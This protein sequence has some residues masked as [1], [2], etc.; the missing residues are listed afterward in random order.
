M[1]LEEFNSAD[2]DGAIA[3]LRPC[4]DVTRW[5]EQIADRRPYGTIEALAAEAAGAA[6]PFT[7]DEVAAALAHHP[8]IGERAD[9][10]SREAAMSRAEQA[11]VDPADQAVQEALNEGNL[12]YEQR[13]GRVFL[14]R[15]AGRDAREILSSLQERLRNDAEAEDRIVAEQLREIALL[16]LKGTVTA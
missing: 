6:A 10:S 15:A 8:R 5:C 7:T 16:R 9:G 11:G 13:F 4:V 2:R 14:I 12:A 1:L 3:A